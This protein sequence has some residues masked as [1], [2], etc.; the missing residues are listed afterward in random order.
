MHEAETNAGL[1]IGHVLF[2]DIVG[3][4]KRTVDEQK[5]LV[6]RLNELVRNTAQFRSAD[7]AGKLIRIPTGDGM[8]LAF[9]TSPDAPVNCAIELAKAVGQALPPAGE[10]KRQAGALAL[11]MRMGIHSGP[12]DR[13]ADVNERTN[14]A[15]AGMNMAQRVMDCG[16]AGHILLSQRI[17]D[18]LAQYDRWR[19]MLHNLGEVELKH[20]VRLGIVSLHNGEFGNA[21]IP[22][23]IKQAQEERAAFLRRAEKARRRRITLDA[24][25]AVLLLV[26]IGVGMWVWQ[27]H[28]ALTSAEKLSS[29][30][31]VEKSVAVLPFENLSADPDNAFFTDG[32]QDEI[33]NNLAKIGDLKVISRTS[34][35]QYKTDVKRNVREIANAL[36]VAHVV[37]GSVQRVANRVRVSAQLIDAKTDRHLWVERYDR[38]LDDVFAIQT[39]IAKAIAGQLQ[40]K[41]SSDEKTAIKQPPTTNLIAYDRYVRAEK[42]SALPRIPDDVY[43]IIRLLNQAVAYDPTFLLAYCKLADKHAWLYSLGVDHTPARLALAN[44]ARDAA[45]RLGPDRGEAHLAAA[46]VAYNG[47]RDYETALTEVGIARSSLPNDTSVLNITAHIARRQGHWKQSTSDFERAA[48]L[49][50]R[51][52]WFLSRL[53]INYVS[54]R[55]FPEAAA[56][57]DR[58]LAVEPGNPAMRFG[59]ALLDFHSRANTQPAEEAVQ[60]IVTKDPSGMDAVADMWFDFALCRR[61]ATEMAK[62]LASLPAEGNRQGLPIPRSFLEGLAARTRNDASGAE[63]AFTAA[64]IELE[65][66]LRQQPDYAQALCTLGIIDAALGRKEDALREGRRAGELLPVT[67]DA[68]TGASL[69]RNLAVIYVWAGEKDLAIKQLEELL[70]IPSE[71]TYGDLRLNPFWDPLRGDPRFEQLLEESKKPV[72]LK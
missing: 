61:D 8:A 59:R 50:P 22:A 72:A 49:D 60:S 31:T 28:V 55:R 71:I 47:Y 33:L 12:V 40:A 65:G 41:L 58:A 23:R 32:M 46:Y 5:E 19:P 4:S 25:A 14:L 43:E 39:D 70:R 13:L 26:S 6:T 44:E 57:L 42:L 68:I 27:R 51:S 35:M 2:I 11:Q 53:A 18:D 38:P 62:A 10:K 48:E 37:E 36:G 69:L 16:D 30:A 54:Q 1:E 7:A 56:A 34:V 67:N 64:R 15:G 24:A 17:A 20:G 45:L 3:Y 52:V 29:A 21:A 66:I 63:A 9:F